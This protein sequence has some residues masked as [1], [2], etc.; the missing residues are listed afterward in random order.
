MSNNIIIPSVP[1]DLEKMAKMVDDACL[2]KTRI[3]LERK[4]LTDVVEDIAETFDIPKK[5]VNQMI[6]CRDK[7]SYKDKTQENED[8]ELLYESVFKD[9][10]PDED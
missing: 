2:I 6:A 4:T 1:E 5:Y 7:D 8:F 9:A 3:A 10:L